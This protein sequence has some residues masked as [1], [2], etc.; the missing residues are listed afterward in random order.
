VSK[1]YCHACG[2]DVERDSQKRWMYSYCEKTDKMVRIFRKNR[3]GGSVE[4]VTSRNPRHFN[5]GG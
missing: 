4:K 1:Y 5:A 3:R 2:K